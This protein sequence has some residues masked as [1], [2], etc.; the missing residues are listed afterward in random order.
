MRRI[1]F[2]NKKT[3]EV[4]DHDRAQDFFIMADGKVWGDNGHTYES[5]AQ[6]IGF[7]DCIEL[8]PGVDWRVVEDG[9]PER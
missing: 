7:E 4:F 2:F 6:T 8:C 9:E 1:E 5:Q 3:G